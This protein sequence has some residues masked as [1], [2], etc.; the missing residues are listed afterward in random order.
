MYSESC[1]TPRGALAHQQ[2]GESLCGW[3][4]EAEAAARLRAEGI[5]QRPSA[6][7]GTTA[8][9]MA[10]V[11]AVQAAVNRAILSAEVEA[12]ERDHPGES[13]RRA[14]P[15]RLIAGNGRTETAA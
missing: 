5:P 4:L 1:G 8:A 9:Y 11:S 13:G 12:Y 6:A 15:L 10:P 14:G 7:P 3:C 2:A